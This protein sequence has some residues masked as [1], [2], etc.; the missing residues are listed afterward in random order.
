MAG[1]GHGRGLRAHASAAR[2]DELVEK[3]DCFHPNEQTAQAMAVNL[4]NSMIAPGPGARPQSLAVPACPVEETS[5]LITASSSKT[6][7]P[8]ESRRLPLTGLDWREGRC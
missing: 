1:A 2:R 4:Y 5:A 8:A 6:R 7:A 3:F